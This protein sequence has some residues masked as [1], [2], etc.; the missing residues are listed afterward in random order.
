MQKNLITYSLISFLIISF[1]GFNFLISLLGNILIILFLTP[2]LLVG[3]A[4]L[5]INFFKSKIN[6]CDN[7]GSAILSDS[8][9]CL[10]CGVNLNKYDNKK[11]LSNEASQETVE[12]DAEEIK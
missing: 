12:I 8:S 6:F 9:N 11:N 3:L 4:F 10:Y 2:V 5:G 1:F 7:C